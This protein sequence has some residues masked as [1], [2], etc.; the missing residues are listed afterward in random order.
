MR[1][2]DPVGRS[3]R[4]DLK[5]GVL[6]EAPRF[7]RVEDAFDLPDEQL[8]DPV[9][10]LLDKAKH[11]RVKRALSRL[12]VRYQELYQLVFVE[13]RTFEEAGQLLGGLSKSWTSRLCKDL[14]VQVK[15][16]LETE[17][18]QG[19]PNGFV[20]DESQ[21]KEKPMAT[22]SSGQRGNQAS[23]AVVPK[24]SA[25]EPP[26]TVVLV[27]GEGIKGVTIPTLN[28]LFPLFL[29]TNAAPFRSRCIQRYQ[30]LGFPSHNA[31]QFVFGTLKELGVLNNLEKGLWH[32]NLEAVPKKWRAAIAV[33]SVEHAD[34][35]TPARAEEAAPPVNERPAVPCAPLAAAAVEQGPPDLASRVA[36]LE[37][38]QVLSE[39]REAGL[40]QTLAQL[41]YRDYFGQLTPDLQRELLLC[42]AERVDAKQER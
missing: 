8:I 40:L 15:I 30:A 32:W 37:A 36:Q 22:A 2:R 18:D 26:A 12:S 34:L 24:M 3:I 31:M 19:L 39:R 29:E 13:E 17:L 1:E 41:C 21:S 16:L 33:H 5:S 25:P 14:L 6:K 38:R 27:E 20:T 11:Q 7:V 35:P 10:R 42:L 9:D 28:R 23:K 4:A